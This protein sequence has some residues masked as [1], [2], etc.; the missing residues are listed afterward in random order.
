MR[1]NKVF[2]VNNKK[3]F[4]LFALIIVI[5][6]G[7]FIVSFLKFNTIDNQIKQSSFQV[8]DDFIY[9][10]NKGKKF[11]TEI[12]VDLFNTLI[13]IYVNS[14]K[15]FETIFKLS[16]EHKKIN[17]IYLLTVLKRNALVS[18]AILNKKVS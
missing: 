6:I 14:N 16:M 13:Q 3:S 9:I 11:N 8:I 18:E 15:E 12:S 7:L 10:I 1:K 2:S 4:V 5:I 17:P